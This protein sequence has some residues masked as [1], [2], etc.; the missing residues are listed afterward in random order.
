M[1][2]PDPPATAPHPSALK[3]PARF[4][5]C[6]LPD[7]TPDGRCVYSTDALEHLLVAKLG[8][9]QEEAR[10]WLLDVIADFV[11]ADC[12]LDVLQTAALAQSESGADADV[13]AALDLLLAQMKLGEQAINDC[14]STSGHTL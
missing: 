7:L 6:M 10:V 9:S 1:P 8:Y 4:D 3:L 2:S 12:M 11:V 14:S 5:R 13:C